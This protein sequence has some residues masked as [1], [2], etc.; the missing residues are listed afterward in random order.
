MLTNYVIAGILGVSAGEERLP[1]RKGPRKM[2]SAPFLS[3]LLHRVKAVVRRVVRP[4]GER[5]RSVAPD[6]A[7]MAISPVLR[8]LAQ[9]W[10]RVRLRALSAL[11]RRIEAGE[12]LDR[13]APSRRKAV[14]MAFPREPA[15]EP[16]EARL[17]RGFGWMCG[18]EPN[19]RQDGAAFAEWLSEPAMRAKVLAAPERM[20]R[21]IGPILTATG[22]A[23]PEWFPAVAKR[24]KRSFPAR[25]GKSDRDLETAGASDVAPGDGGDVAGDRRVKPGD[26]YCLI[27]TTPARTTVLPIVG[28]W[29]RCYRCR[30]RAQLS[31]FVCAA[32]AGSTSCCLMEDAISKIGAFASKTIH[33]HF[34]T[35]S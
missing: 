30:T 10:V 23:R 9:R 33:A 2:F 32:C 20:A 26:D 28:T 6:A 11:M 14:P 21:A 3:T 12:R 35:M 25:T 13:P 34:V 15:P 5:A 1:P 27:A 24:V 19:L 4:V 18:F 29:T 8:G 31:F 17:P 22:A 16:A 7:G